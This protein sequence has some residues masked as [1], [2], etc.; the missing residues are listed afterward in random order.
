MTAYI[1][2]A[3]CQEL[4]RKR[5]G[6]GAAASVVSVPGRVNLIGEHVDYHN[7]PVLPM[8][9]QRR[10]RIAFRPRGDRRIRAVSGDG[11]GEREFDWTPKLEPAA[12]GDWVN[13]LRAAAQA[14]ADRWGTGC[15]I[16]AAIVSDL[17]PAA[18]LS[19]SSAL[20]TGFTLALLEANDRR[21]TFEELMGVLP[22]GEYFVGTRGGGMDHAAVLACRP[23]SALLVHFAPVSVAAVAV[24]PDWAFLVA[25]SLTTAEKSGAVRAEF[26]A[27]RT[28]G[29]RALDRLGFPSFAAA[30]AAPPCD[31]D[32]L[33]DEERRS[34]LHV[35]SEA[36]RVEDAVSA[37]R[38][39]DA[40]EFGRILDASHESLRDQLR[41]SS[42]ALDELVAAARDAGALGARLTG[43]GFGGCAVILTTVADRERVA[44]GLLQRYYSGRQGFD[45]SI[46]LIAAE[47][48]AGAL[49]G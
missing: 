26:N 38:N 15:G 41:V 31:L 37:L 42:P 6:P 7:L 16:D 27:R 24:P 46:H 48:S 49:F 2:M 29:S 32:T 3:D 5:F 4:L 36:R 8:A 43:A 40:R 39:S 13:Y 19:S 28:A 10:I 14:V 33:S 30:L 45:P 1:A 21:A 22:E 23:G 44:A 9:I 18:G 25:H 20:L 17:P 47:P 11:F 35:V 12:A 34:F